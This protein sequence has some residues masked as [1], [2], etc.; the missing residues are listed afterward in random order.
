ME[1]VEE[2]ERDEREMKDERVRVRKL[3]V[4][5]SDGPEVTGLQ[6]SVIDLSNDVDGA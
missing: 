3:F 1:K 2:R 4:S 5:F 6:V